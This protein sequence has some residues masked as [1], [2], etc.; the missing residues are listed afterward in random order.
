MECTLPEEKTVSY[1]L[2]LAGYITALLGG[3]IGLFIGNHILTSYIS[4]QGEEIF[5]FD[6]G[7]RLHGKIITALAVSMIVICMFINLALKI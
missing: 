6:E 2:L 1:H 3:M 4:D 7:S 5:K